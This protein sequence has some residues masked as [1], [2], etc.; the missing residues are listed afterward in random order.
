MPHPVIPKGSL[1]EVHLSCAVGKPHEKKRSINVERE[2]TIEQ[3][4]EQY[5]LSIGVVK[6][7][8]IFLNG[9][10]VPSSAKINEGCSIEFTNPDFKIKVKK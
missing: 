8:N 6:G 2:T 4:M 3:I 10:R 9:V 7:C 5:G 1:L